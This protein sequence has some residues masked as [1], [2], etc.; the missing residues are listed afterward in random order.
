MEL[1]SGAGNQSAVRFCTS[2][3]MMAFELLSTGREI[4]AENMMMRLL[5][6]RMMGLFAGLAVAG[7]AGGAERRDRKSVV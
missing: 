5:R 4:F 6:V 7:F 3:L 1:W 2:R